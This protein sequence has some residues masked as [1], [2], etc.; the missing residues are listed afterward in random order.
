MPSA[1]LDLSEP[2]QEPVQWGLTALLVK[3]EPV[4]GETDMVRRQMQ[5]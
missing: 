1:R 4:S 2:T 5:T 3:E